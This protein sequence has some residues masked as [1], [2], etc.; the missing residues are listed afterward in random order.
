MKGVHA[1]IEM[2][3]TDLYYIEFH[4]VYS[5]LMKQWNTQVVKSWVRVQPTV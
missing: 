5:S 1:K 3:W 2:N 4:K